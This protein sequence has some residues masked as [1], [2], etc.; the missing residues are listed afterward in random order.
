MN[1]QCGGFVTIGRETAE[2]LELVALPVPFG[3]T[4][5]VDVGSIHGDSTL[6]GMYMMAMTGNHRA[7]RTADTVFIK[8][9]ETKTNVHFTIDDED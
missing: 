1:E 9:P 5:L 4:L 6:T 8:N 2:S 7:M 3:Y